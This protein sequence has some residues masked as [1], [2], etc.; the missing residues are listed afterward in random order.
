MN[1]HLINVYRPMYLAVAAI[2]VC[3]M[4]G[5]AVAKLEQELKCQ[6]LA[7]QETNGHE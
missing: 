3:F 1:T 4:F 5:A 6:D 7:M 2:A